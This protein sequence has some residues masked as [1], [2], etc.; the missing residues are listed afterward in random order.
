MPELPE[1]ET[2]VREL[3]DAGLVGRRVEH[4]RVAWP[5]TV[6][7]PSVATFRR[8][9]RGA[10]FTGL[11]RRGKY[12]VFGLS[13]P[14]TLLV[15]LRM[16]GHF[17]MPDRAVPHSPHEHI[18]LGLDDGRDLR[19]NDTRKFGRF[20]LRRDPDAV[21]GKLGPEPLDRT[22]RLGVFRARIAARRGM[23]KPLLLNQ[24]FLA[25]MGNI[26]VDEALWDAQ[27]HPRRRA[28]TL[29]ADG[30]ARLYGA[31]RK[32]LR[33]GIRSLGTTLEDGLTAYRRV[34]GQY[35][36]N[37]EK[38]RVFRRTGQPCPRCGEPIQRIVVSQRSTH[39][40]PRC[41]PNSC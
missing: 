9:L 4:V 38:L 1:V 20:S 7:Q 11:S 16:T 17:A 30:Q 15:H 12:L 28:E 24:S 29:T 40:C 2:V 35:G 10:C 33:R 41:Q 34:G 39:V 31:I 27:L 8:R 37:R 21:L 6:A 13:I 36:S 32:V 25:G 19:F 14:E 23:L 26:Y 5:R 22:F 18:V 3:R